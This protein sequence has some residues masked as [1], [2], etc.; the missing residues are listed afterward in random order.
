MARLIGETLHFILLSFVPS[1]E[2]FRRVS[3]WQKFTEYVQPVYSCA[4]AKA[5]ALITLNRR[6][7]LGAVYLFI[8]YALVIGARFSY[9]QSREGRDL[10]RIKYRHCACRQWPLPDKYRVAVNFI[11]FSNLF[12]KLGSIIILFVLATIKKIISHDQTKG[13]IKYYYNRSVPMQ[14]WEEI[15]FLKFAIALMY[16]W[17]K[18]Y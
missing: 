14:I 6:W 9:I 18:E 17:A 7:R 12:S 8:F 3:P 13:L 16:K 15:L 11:F 10:P 4:S 1:G 2:L 5:W